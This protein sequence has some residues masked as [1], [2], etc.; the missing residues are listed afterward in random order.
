MTPGLSAEQ[1]T[2]LQ[3][4]TARHKSVFIT[5]PAG[6]GKSFL[7]RH[8]VQTMPRS[9]VYVTG[10]T[11]ISALNAKGTTLHFFAGIGRGRSAARKDP[12]IMTSSGRMRRERQYETDFAARA[13]MLHK[14]KNN[15]F[16]LKKWQKC[17]VLIIDEISM[18]S[19]ELWDDLEWLARMTR[20][21][22]LPFGGIQLVVV[23]DM[24]QLPPVLS[25]LM[26]FQS[27]SWS[28]CIDKVY[29]LKT[30]HRQKK[31]RMFAQLLA[32]ARLGKV[33]AG[34]M[35]TLR[36]RLVGPGNVPPQGTPVLC[37]LRHEARE[38]N[39]R[40]MSGLVTPLRT[41][42]AEDRGK[43][44]HFLATLDKSCAAIKR[45]KLKVGARVM[46]I[47]N[48][49]VEM[50]LVNGTMG[51]VSSLGEVPCVDFDGVGNTL[52]EKGTWNICDGSVVLAE[53]KQ[54]PL[55]LAWAVTIHRSQSLTMSSA[56]VHVDS[57][58]EVGQAYTALSRVRTLDGLYIK[59]ELS[60]NSFKVSR[61]AVQ[62]YEDLDK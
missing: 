23:G 39:T 12:M 3:A 7:L 9:G 18:I 15:A 31:D 2:V 34:H 24:C 29:Y 45:L 6:T 8:I 21:S 51:T 57:I 19:G 42:I 28:R 13:A 16:A 61:A 59:G 14:I 54:W 49:D 56:V 60:P 55:V 5:G 50:G 58:F 47:V 30:V 40:K 52:L 53:R 26:T 35:K 37:S 33:G 10:S 41:Y 46:L 48:K 32:R 27:E 44:D 38:V 25:P 11:G 62:F 36:R 4:V 22:L 43:H 1:N 17:R 20:E